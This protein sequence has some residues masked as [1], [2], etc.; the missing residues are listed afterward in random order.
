M[1]DPKSFDFIVSEIHFWTPILGAFAG[2]WKA[3]SFMKNHV[4]TWADTLLNNHLAHVQ[5]SLDNLC[6][7]NAQQVELLKQ[8]ADK[9]A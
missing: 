9:N 7:A 5:Q 1:S 4:N 8:I 6:E 3:Y 2:G